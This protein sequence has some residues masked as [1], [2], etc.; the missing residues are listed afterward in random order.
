MAKQR[1]FDGRVKARR[2]GALERRE[3]D[4]KKWSAVPKGD[5]PENVQKKLEHAQTDVVNLYAKLGMKP[6]DG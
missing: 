4:V 1:N 3:A 2:Q 5:E 6:K